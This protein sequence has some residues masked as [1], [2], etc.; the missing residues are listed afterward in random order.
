[1]SHALFG[2][3][4]LALVVAGSP[5][6]F[7][8]APMS[9]PNPPSLSQARF[10]VWL[11]LVGIRPEQADVI[12]AGFGRVA[13]EATR[14][15][16]AGRMEAADLMVRVTVGAA[17]PTGPGLA[18]FGGRAAGAERGAGGF[19]TEAPPT[20]EVHLSIVDVL[21]GSFLMEETVTCRLPLTQGSA[22]VA[23]CLRTRIP[24]MVELMDAWAENEATNLETAADFGLSENER[25]SLGPADLAA[26]YYREGVLAS[27]AG[28]EARALELMA[29]AQPLFKETG[30]RLEE[31]AAWKQLAYLMAATHR[32]LD[33]AIDYAGTAVR[34]ARELSDPVGEARALC[35][36]AGCEAR[37][38]NYSRAARIARSAARRARDNDDAATEGTSIAILAGLAA[39]RGDFDQARALQGHALELVRA[40]GNHHASARVLLSIAA[41]TAHD[42]DRIRS[43][44]MAQLDEAREMALE[45][46][47]MVLLR[48]VTFAM[49][50]TRYDTTE[51]ELVIAGEVDTIRAIK[52]SSRLDD[53]IGEAAAIG[54]LGAFAI[55][56]GKLERAF[57]YLEVAQTRAVDADFVEG[58]TDSFQVMGETV[59]D[60]SHGVTLLQTV[61]G[62]RAE[63]GDLR[64]QVKTLSD[65]SRL[66]AGLERNEE[67]WASYQGAVTAAGQYIA[68]LQENRDH[69]DIRESFTTV[70]KSL[71]T[72]R[73]ELPFLARYLTIDRM[74]PLLNPS[75]IEG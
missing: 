60:L 37:N 5:L 9:S 75:W 2:L 13:E 15:A 72:T 65:L 71:M 57:E 22:I 21:D 59:P 20:I 14:L 67:A 30:M 12:T 74:L 54:L 55:R 36:L 23:P 28:F 40:T 4:L 3:A 48:D 19:P 43:A 53:K 32:G 27:R 33:R 51:M 29:E 6:H 58:A 26:A 61:V 39:V 16:P 64:G 1:M 24:R 41:V 31:G 70:L 69:E 38:G 17:Q 46:G 66:Q 73:T 50:N 42:D 47:D 68:Q 56:L 11:E 63:Q 8:A 18:D 25:A 52:L 44:S 62:L 35:L 45:S 49:A 7:P 10:R 34:I